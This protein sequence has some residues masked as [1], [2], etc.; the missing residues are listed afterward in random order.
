MCVD[1]RPVNNTTRS[2]RERDGRI[3]HIYIVAMFVGYKSERRHR[4]TNNNNNKT[5]KQQEKKEN[6]QLHKHDGESGG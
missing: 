1:T 4:K 2:E 5:E 3:R 6:N